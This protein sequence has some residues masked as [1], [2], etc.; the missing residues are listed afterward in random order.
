MD[1]VYTTRRSFP[2]PGGIATAM[3]STAA[4]LARSHHLRVFAARVDDAPLDRLNTTVTA[5]SFDP[6]WMDHVEIRP[7][8]MGVSQFVRAAPMSLMTVPGL[9]RYG[10]GFLRRSTASG[11]VRS[12]GA[13][14]ASM[15]G[16]AE[17]LHAWGGE[18]TNWAGGEAAKRAEVPLVVTPFAHPGHWGDDA[19]N[20]AF[21]AD[22]DAVLT[23][24]PSEAE[25]YTSL[26]VR[27]ERLHVVGVPVTPLPTEDL[28]EVRIEHGLGDDPIVLFLGVKERYKGYRSLMEAAEIVWTQRPETR[29][30]FVGPP[31]EDSIQ[32]FESVT[33][34]RIL[35]RGRVSDGEVA[36][37]HRAATAFCLPSTSEIM[38]V[39]ILEAWQ[40]GTPVVAAR[41]WCAHDLINDGV[42]GIIVEPDSGVIARALL[43]LLGD[44][45]TARAM[46]E[47]GR[48]KVAERYTPEAVAARHLEAYQRVVG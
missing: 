20:A 27:P 17:V 29:F 25:Y 19:M 5:G 14:L 44:P 21:Y 7:M 8:P 10:Y 22:A 26:G 23:L 4:V 16:D 37:W 47:A 3:R 43:G 6:F 33:D 24:V 32:D 46:G 38:P 1:I 39:S 13:R 12:V 48:T 42:D 36:A 28:P 18:H 45:A 15:L 9:R 34:P 35:E 40:A 41:W 11:Y 30:V 2:G 31:T